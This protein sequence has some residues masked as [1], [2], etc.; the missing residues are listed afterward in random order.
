MRNGLN[1]NVLS[2]SLRRSEESHHW[3]RLPQPR[4][5]LVL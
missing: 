4:R 3:S 2:K 1:D 5:G